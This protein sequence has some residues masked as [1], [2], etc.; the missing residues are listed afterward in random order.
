MSVL[1]AYRLMSAPGA[2]MSSPGAHAG[3][4]QYYYYGSPGHCRSFIY[5]IIN[6]P[7]INNT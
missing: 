6:S 5:I 7:G 4:K 1:S 3:V 2:H